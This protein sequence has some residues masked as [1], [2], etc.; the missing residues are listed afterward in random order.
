MASLDTGVNSLGTG[1][2]VPSNVWAIGTPVTLSAQKTGIMI[3]NLR[4]SMLFQQAVIA[5]TKCENFELRSCAKMRLAAGLYPDPLG[6][7]SAPQIYRESA[8][9]G[10]RVSRFGARGGEKKKGKNGRE[11]GCPSNVGSGS[12]P[13][14]KDTGKDISYCSVLCVLTGSRNNCI[15][16][17]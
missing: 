12:T 14:F 15:D 7:L 3:W 5:L 16:I 10:R 1:G 4:F 6:S 13:S 9:G 17:A 2:H 8:C 11:D